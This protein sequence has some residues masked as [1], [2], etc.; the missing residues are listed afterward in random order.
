MSK[1]WQNLERDIATHFGVS[2]NIRRGMDWSISD[3]DVDVIKEPVWNPFSFIIDCKYRAN[4]EGA[5]CKLMSSIKHP[6]ELAPIIRLRE[7]S[8]WYHICRLED[9]TMSRI[10]Y[11]N[12]RLAISEHRNNTFIHT[13]IARNGTKYIDKWFSKMHLVYVPMKQEEYELDYIIPIIALRQ[14]G[15]RQTLIITEMP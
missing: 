11:A 15:V 6:A 9:F 7:G 4:S 13:H 1:A 2:R 12:G 5:L 3:T 8:N 14:K 10:D